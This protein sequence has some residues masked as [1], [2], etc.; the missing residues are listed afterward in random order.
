MHISQNELFLDNLKKQ[1][2]HDINMHLKQHKPLVSETY[3][4]EH[5]DP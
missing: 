2:S 3:D 1:F 4:L 5:K